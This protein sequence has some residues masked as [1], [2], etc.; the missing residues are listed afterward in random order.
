MIRALEPLEAIRDARASAVARYNEDAERIRRRRRAKRRARVL[1]VVWWMLVAAAILIVAVRVQQA[2]GQAAIVYEVDNG[3]Q[4]RR[5]LADAQPG[6]VIDIKSVGGVDVS[7]LG[8]I[9]CR[10]GVTL[11]GQGMD[12][13]TL[14]NRNAE[15]AAGCLWELYGNTVIEDI[16]LV[17]GNPD[18]NNGKQS[19]GVAGF[20]R[21][22]GAK[23]DEL[24]PRDGPA[25]AVL[26]R[27]RLVGRMWGLYSWAEPGN[28]LLFDD[29][30]I[31]TCRQGITLGNSSGVDGQHIE[32]R[33]STITVDT[34][35]DGGTRYH[36]AVAAGCFGIA[37]RGGTLVVKNTTIILRGKGSD[38]TGNAKPRVAAITDYYGGEINPKESP[39]GKS[40]I[41]VENCTLR[42]EGFDD[43]DDSR[44]FDIDQG[45]P[46]LSITVLGATTGSGPGG[47]VI[48]NGNVL[49]GKLRIVRRAP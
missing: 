28:R 17:D 29:G 46:G 48:A 37:V 7:A 40:S 43:V 33:D 25:D 34:D 45:Q 26:R 15:A 14:I 16:T 18:H 27:V 42:I 47:A 20:A 11:R 22:D 3:P 31:E 32:I 19:S 5:A 4:Y 10:D 44:K 23:R 8:M 12:Q 2:R 49:M 24:P 41:I 6:D 39:G 1:D 13:T 38:I 9:A 36:G 30:E 35:R 21:N